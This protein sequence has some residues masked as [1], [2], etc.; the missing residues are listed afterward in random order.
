M[1]LLS[2]VYWLLTRLRPARRQ[3]A[4]RMIRDFTHSKFGEEFFDAASPQCGLQPVRSEIAK[5]R[6][7]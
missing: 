1:G 3:I 2:F 5:D 6:R 7:R 4:D